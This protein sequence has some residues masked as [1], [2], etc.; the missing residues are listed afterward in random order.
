MVIVVCD[1]PPLAVE[2]DVAD[3]EEDAVVVAEGVL[4][5]VPS[6]QFD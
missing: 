6:T 1:N 2:E 5:G 4:V 3:G